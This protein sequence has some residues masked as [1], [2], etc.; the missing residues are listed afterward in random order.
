MLCDSKKIFIMLGSA[1]NMGCKYCIQHPMVREQIKKEMNPN[2]M[3]WIRSMADYHFERTGKELEVC[4]F[5]GEPLLYFHSIRKIIKECGSKHVQYSMITNGMAMTEE[6]VD[7]LNEHEVHVAISWD[8]EHVG[9]TRG[10]DVFDSTKGHKEILLKLKY[11]CITGVVTSKNYPRDIL[12]AMQRIDDE[13]Y[14]I[15]GHHISVNLD[16]IFGT[17]L[18]DPELAK[19]DKGKLHEQMME[20]IAEFDSYLRGENAD[21]CTVSWFM[22]YLQTYHR[23]HGN[24]NYPY[25]VN[26][27]KVLNVDLAGNLYLCHNTGKR[28]GHISMP[29]VRYM[30]RATNFGDAEKRNELCNACRVRDLCGQYCKL[31]DE[32]KADEGYCDLR[33]AA[34]TP[35]INYIK[36][37][38]S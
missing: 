37:V 12:K 4:F 23:L 16:F 11:L 8:G 33:R 21:D 35:I 24:E 34:L 30:M 18:P 32:S 9:E 28:L 5:G 10:Y 17:N 1:C 15:H 13:Y 7:F 29:T 26:G 36:G 27:W 20:L 22:R 2:L 6:M 19:V 25:C 3:A 14:P 38:K 31:I